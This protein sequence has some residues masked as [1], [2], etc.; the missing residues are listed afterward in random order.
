M[1]S[2]GSRAR[3]PLRAVTSDEPTRPRR[4]QPGVP[5]DLEAL[6]LHCLEKEPARHYP[7]ALA[8][9]EDLRRFQEGKQVVARPVGAV[10]RLGR[11]CRR[12]PL[13]KLLLALLTLSL[14]GGMSGITWKWLEA[15]ELRDRANTHA[16]QADEEKQAALYQ[17]QEALYQAYRTS[18]A[19]ASGALENHDVADAARH[20][21]SA[22][23]G[24]R[25]WEW[26]HLHSR[27]DE[28]SAVVPLPAGQG[29]LIAGVDQ[30]RIGVLTSAGLRIMDLEGHEQK[31]VPIGLDRRRK[32][33]RYLEGADNP[34]LE[35]V[36]CEQVKH[37]NGAVHDRSPHLLTPMPQHVQR[38]DD[39]DQRQITVDDEQVMD[40]QFQHAPHHFGRRGIQRNGE[41]GR[42]HDLTY[43]GRVHYFDRA[44]IGTKDDDE[45]GGGLDE[46]AESGLTSLLGQAQAMALDQT[47]QAGAANAVCHPALGRS[48]ARRLEWLT[49]PGDALALLSPG[50]N[51]ML[52]LADRA[53][54]RVVAGNIRDSLEV[55]V[56]DWDKPAPSSHMLLK[57]SDYR[58]YQRSWRRN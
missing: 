56:S 9:A 12:R 32:T 34:Y 11:L 58:F 17:K 4:L 23:E 52:L 2:P 36:Q 18:L 31:T 47:S 21:Q 54:K 40:L 43:R 30:L 15:N 48:S 16:R 7:S 51:R 42:R 20:L 29:L 41:D 27:L 19:A 37:R 46:G 45:A 14:F 55:P 53:M 13:I 33:R 1:A 39:A 5:R 10:A 26:R 49:T 38:T 57:E 28:S 24:L 6:T 3:R 50:G 22:P 25:G 44:S 35:E 8:L